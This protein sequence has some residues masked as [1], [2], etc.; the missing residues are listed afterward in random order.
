MVQVI[1]GW[2]QGLRGMR[3]VT[4]LPH[5]DVSPHKLMIA[6]SFGL[7]SMFSVAV[8]CP[9][10]FQDLTNHNP[11]LNQAQQKPFGFPSKAAA[12]LPRKLPTLPPL[13]HSAPVH[14]SFPSTTPPSPP[15]PPLP[16]HDCT[17]SPGLHPPPRG[18]PWRGAAGRRAQAG[19]PARAGLRQGGHPGRA[20]P[21]RRHPLLRRQAPPRLNRPGRAGERPGGAARL[22][23]RL[24][25]PRLGRARAGQRMRRPRRCPGGAARRLPAWGTPLESGAR[26]IRVNGPRRPGP[27]RPVLREP[28]RAAEVRGAPRRRPG[29][30]ERPG[31]ACREEEGRAGHAARGVPKQALSEP[32]F[33]PLATSVTVNGRGGRARQRSRWTRIAL[34]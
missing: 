6:R 4:I 11:L 13:P 2:D 18:R 23:P 12:P 34:S 10:V 26:F 7:V 21:P 9:P 14:P 30:P 24:D 15:S 3:Q 28:A 33:L 20:D 22:R 29:R 5:A 17:T 31:R 8:A 32:S 25:A 19:D 27:A 1:K 16:S